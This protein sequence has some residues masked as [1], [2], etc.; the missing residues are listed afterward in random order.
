ML[1]SFP[2][3]SSKCISLGFYQETFCAWS[4]VC[5][6]APGGRPTLCGAKPQ[7]TYPG[8]SAF[9]T[10]WLAI[11]MDL[12]LP[13]RG[14]GAS[15]FPAFLGN[16]SFLIRAQSCSVC[17]QLPPLLWFLRNHQGHG[18]IYQ[19][20]CLALLYKDGLTVKPVT[21]L[22]LQVQCHIL[23]C[24]VNSLSFLKFPDGAFPLRQHVL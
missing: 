21:C 7:S 3:P 15:H 4:S 18:G 22:R 10:Q 11:S 2:F 19:T 16:V 6:G 12:T 1:A 13:I 24:I 17:L 8:L 9:P 14:I 20:G 23:A 5:V